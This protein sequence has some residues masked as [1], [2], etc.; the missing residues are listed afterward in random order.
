MP[1][2]LIM[3]SPYGQRPATAR[4]RAVGGS[5][6]VISLFSAEGATSELLPATGLVPPNPAKLRFAC[7]PA[8]HVLYSRR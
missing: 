4:P 7:S 6:H 5:R 2:T 3:W 1:Q 8:G